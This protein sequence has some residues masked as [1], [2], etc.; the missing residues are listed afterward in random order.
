MILLLGKNDAVERYAKEILNIDLDND[1]AY[2][3]DVIT[4]YSELSQW[5][6]LARREN[7]PVVTTQRLDMINEFLHSDLDLKVITAVEID[8]NIRARVVEKEKALYIKEELGLELRWIPHFLRNFGG[9]IFLKVVGNKENVN[10]IKLTHKG[11]NIEFNC[12]MKPLLY[13]ADNIDI[14]K[15]ERIEITF[16]DSYEIDNLIHILEK[17]KKEYSEYIGEW[18]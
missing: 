14:S 17:F 18:R 7:P 10:Q 13:T 8:G 2:Y 11:L 6:E 16:K 4:H 9:E 1:I 5:V 12:F 15:P 3:P